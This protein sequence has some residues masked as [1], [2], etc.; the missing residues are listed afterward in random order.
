[1]NK[2]FDSRLDGPGGRC[3]SVLASDVLGRSRQ[4]LQSVDRLDHVHESVGLE[5]IALQRANFH[6]HRRRH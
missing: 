4:V 1:M 2:E 5:T 3:E 6:A